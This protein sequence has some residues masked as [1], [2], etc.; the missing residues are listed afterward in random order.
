MTAGANPLTVRATP[1]SVAGPPTPAGQFRAFVDAFERLGYDVTRLLRAIGV[2]RADL[3]DPDALIPCAASGALFAQAMR[4]RPLHNLGMHLAAQ[5]PIGAFGL[6]DYLVLTADTVADGWTLL[7]R[8]LRRLA[9]APFVLELRDDRDPIECVFRPDPSVAPAGTE[10]A[11]A[12]AVFHLRKETE[13]QLRFS[14]VS[15]THRPDDVPE[16]ER[17]FGCPV[18]PIAPWAGFAVP[19]NAWRTPHRR[20]DPLLHRV[21]EGHAQS[22][23]PDG[24]THALEVDIRRVLAS[25]LPTGEVDIEHVARDLGMSMRT[26][27]RR[28]AAAGV[29]YHEVLESARREAAERCIVHSALAIGEIAYLLGYSEPAAFHRAFKRWTGET[30]QAFRQRHRTDRTL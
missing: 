1:A 6:L 10:F 2:Q 9:G 23:A 3:D 4:E 28:L 5:T 14:Y 30:P 27:Q 25:R 18:R 24:A 21:L 16:M 29:S 12:L 8:Y 11:I 19:E 20:K 13:N 26:L 17:M 15:F 22:I 7:A